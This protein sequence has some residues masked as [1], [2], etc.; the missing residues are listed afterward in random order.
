[1]MQ[2]DALRSK[3]MRLMQV[4]SFGMK[5][6]DDYQSYPDVLMYRLESKK[7]QLQIGLHCRVLIVELARFRQ[8]HQLD[9]L[10]PQSAIDRQSAAILAVVVSTVMKQGNS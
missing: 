6:A 9:A 8:S 3:H 1:M 4:K 2:L 5:C 7:L 10:H